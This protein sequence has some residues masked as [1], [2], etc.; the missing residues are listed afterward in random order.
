[1]KINVLLIGSGGREHALAWKIAQS[2]LL[3]VL[4]CAPGNAGICD[5]AQCS[6]ID[7][8]DHDAIIEFSQTNNI[9]L[10]VVGPEAPLVA[11]IVDDL[12]EAGINAFGPDA[13]GAMLEGSKAFT[14]EICDMHDIPAAQY[15][16][17]NNASKAKNYVRQNTLPL[18]IKADG[19]AAGKGVVIAETVAQ[20]NDA[21]DACFEGEF[22]DAG[23]SLVIE[24]FMEGEEAS[25]FAICDGKVAALIGTAQDHKRA[26]DGDKGPNTGGMG[27]YSPASIL[28]QNLINEIMGDIIVPTMA[29]MHARGHPFKGFLYAGLMLTQDGP[30]LI[31]YN[32][33]FGD[34]ECQ[35]I[36]MRLDSDILELMLAA[37]DG[38]LLEHEIELA[39]TCAL[40]IV[41]ASKGYPGSYE[42]G[43]LISGKLDYAEGGSIKIF[44]AGTKIVSD[45]LTAIGGRVLNITAT[46]NSVE[47]A[48]QLAYAAVE[49]IDWPDGFYRTDIGWRE[50]SRKVSDDA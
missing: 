14:H 23:Q 46:G 24:E 20:A 17:F 6:D 39:D 45:K 31:E 25:L 42:K 1:M 22:G 30:K 3:D 44:H 32:V 11:G 29:A 43:T 7:I 27:A 35:P 36:M 4:H 48:K 12:N 8:T 50:I 16:N 41:M 26:Y 13:A 10:V 21:I 9:D 40:N 47:Q 18:V 38:T 37:I 15:A 34:P 2:P 28:T 5:I 49:K 33:R 19:L